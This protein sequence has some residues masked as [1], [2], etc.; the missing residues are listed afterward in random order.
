MENSKQNAL[1]SRIERFLDIMKDGKAYT[2]ALMHTLTNLDRSVVS[3]T[4]R[5]MKE[6][7]QIFVIGRV[8]SIHYYS[9][10]SDLRFRP[11]L[12]AK[13]PVVS[14]SQGFPL[15]HALFAHKSTLNASL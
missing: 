15:M 14:P 11:E 6:N 5:K 4:F 7:R 9:I 12:I 3:Q 8:G 1:E 13:A 10:Q 2:P